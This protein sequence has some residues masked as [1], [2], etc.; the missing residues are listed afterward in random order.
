MSENKTSDANGVIKERRMK[1]TN[2]DRTHTLNQ[3]E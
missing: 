2:I 3:N 1:T